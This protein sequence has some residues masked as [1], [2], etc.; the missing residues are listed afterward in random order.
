MLAESKAEQ[1]FTASGSA[2]RLGVVRECVAPLL[3]DRLLCFCELG[4]AC[5][6]KCDLI[7]G[8]NEE[9]P[10][11]HRDIGQ[12]GICIDAHLRHTIIEKSCWWWR[13]ANWDPP[14][15]SDESMLSS[16][17][18]AEHSMHALGSGGAGGLH[19]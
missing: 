6:V 1:T 3:L 7:A 10:F 11:L 15:Q 16:G 12:D 5:E 9:S 18:I 14:C 13:N 8:G 17:K 4:Y 2:Q 19:L